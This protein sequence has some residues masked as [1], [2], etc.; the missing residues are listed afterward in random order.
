MEVLIL[1]SRY[2]IPYIFCDVEPQS[3]VCCLSSILLSKNLLALIN[4][5]VAMNIITKTCVMY[6]KI[7]DV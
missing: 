1:Q 3:S 7:H 5:W 4:F 2:G 6:Y